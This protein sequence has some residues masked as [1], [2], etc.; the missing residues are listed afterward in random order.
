MQNIIVENVEKVIGQMKG[1][2]IRIKSEVSYIILGVGDETVRRLQEKFPDLTITSNY[3]PNS[4]EYWIGISQLGKSVTWI[5]CPVSNLFFTRQRK[6]DGTQD[7]KSD[8]SE[9]DTDK[10]MQEIIDDL[11]LQINSMGRKVK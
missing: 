9:L 3:F 4:M 6:E 10:L 11:S 5:K 8:V 7:F 1:H 2:L